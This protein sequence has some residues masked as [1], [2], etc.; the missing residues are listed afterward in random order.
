MIVCYLQDKN[1]HEDL[2]MSKIQTCFKN[3]WSIM[4]QIL[5]GGNSRISIRFILSKLSALDQ[6]LVKQ[7]EKTKPKLDWTLSLELSLHVFHQ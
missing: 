5:K 1:G 3:I 4:H 2:C 6:D 7:T